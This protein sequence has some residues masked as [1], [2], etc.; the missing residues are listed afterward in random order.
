MRNNFLDFEMTS[1]SQHESRTWW[2]APRWPILDV[3]ATGLIFLNIYV[4]GCGMRPGP[5]LTKAGGV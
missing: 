3:G 1:V 2:D 4:T 5:S